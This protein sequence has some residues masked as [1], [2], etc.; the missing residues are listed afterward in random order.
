L[1]LEYT[2]AS[3]IDSVLSVSRAFMGVPVLQRHSG[4]AGSSEITIY[5]TS[6]PRRRQR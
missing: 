4:A 6:H 3:G 1:P 2:T 5:T